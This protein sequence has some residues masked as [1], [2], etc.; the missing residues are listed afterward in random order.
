MLKH[1]EFALINDNSPVTLPIA[2]KKQ[3]VTIEHLDMVHSCTFNEIARIVSYTPHLNHL[4]IYHDAQN[5]SI[6]EMTLPI[7]LSKLTRLSIYGVLMPF[8]QFEMFI[9]NIHCQLKVLEFTARWQDFTYLNADRWERFISQ[10]LP[11]L[12]E[13]KFKYYEDTIDSNK[14]SINPE[15]QNQFTSPF[16]IARKWVLS[17]QA[18]SEYIIYSIRPY[19]YIER[20]FSNKISSFVS[21][22]KPWYEYG[23]PP[24]VNSSLQLSK[25]AQLT[26]ADLPPY[27]F[28]ESLYNGID[29][30]LIVTQIYHLVIEKTTVREGMLILILTQ[31][32]QLVSLKIHSLLTEE[33]PEQL[34]K[35]ILDIS[36]ISNITKMCLEEVHDVEEVPWFMSLSYS[37]NYLQINSL[38]DVDIELLIREIFIQTNQGCNEDL[39][40]LCIRIPTANDQLIEK[41]QEMID[42]KRWLVDYTIERITDNIYF[43]WR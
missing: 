41:L 3:F 16:W 25:S 12:E 5:D 15:G 19:K 43:R 35:G 24:I 31:L 13:F 26:F 30:I 22:R 17:V 18:D 11:Q 10:N 27:D 6:D 9:K 2:K 28:Y 20:E 38:H 1:N 39:G 37:L 42:G 33:L 36:D 32:T 34:A 23:Q 7:K 29:S 40:S 4:S 21:S 8:N 14:S